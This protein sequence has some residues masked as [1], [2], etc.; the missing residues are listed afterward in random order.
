MNCTQ[1]SG[2]QVKETLYFSVAYDL[3]RYLLSK[4]NTHIL[5]CANSDSQNSQ[6]YVKWENGTCVY[7]VLAYLDISI[8]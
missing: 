7:N 6:E 5:G 3:L 4:R 2:D 8:N 1:E